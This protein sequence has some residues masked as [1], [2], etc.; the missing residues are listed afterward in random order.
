MGGRIEGRESGIGREQGRFVNSEE[1]KGR[2]VRSKTNCR[3]GKNG[4]KEKERGSRNGRG[5]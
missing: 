2:G 1:K 4:K 5:K 3:W